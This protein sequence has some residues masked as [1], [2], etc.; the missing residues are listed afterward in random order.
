MLSAS[1]RKGKPSNRYPLSQMATAPRAIQKLLYTM[2]E[3]RLRIVSIKVKHPLGKI[4]MGI[5]NS[6]SNFPLK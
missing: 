6:I 1:I 5:P 2:T 3:M 4:I